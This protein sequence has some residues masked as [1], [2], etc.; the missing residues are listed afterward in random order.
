MS[1]ASA[2]SGSSSAAR[3]DRTG[4]LAGLRVIEM[5]GLGPGPFCAMLLADLG[6]DVLRIGRPGEQDHVSSLLALER[7]KAKLQL[8]LKE[9]ASVSALLDLIAVSD[10]LIE[11][12]RPGVMERLGLGPNACLRRNPAL[13][14]GRMTGWGQDG[15]LAAAAGHD[16][17]YIALSGALAAIGPAERPV[18]PLNLVGDFGGGALYL[19]VGILAALRSAAVTGRG[20]VVDAAMSEGAA[21]LMTPFYG[22]YASGAWSL[23]RAS[24]FADGGAHFYSI[25]QSRDGHWWTVAAIEPQFYAAVVQGLGLSEVLPLAEQWD[26]ARW[27]NDKSHFEAAFAER[28]SADLAAAFD[29]KD[30]CV[31]RVLDMKT[32]PMHPHN[33]AREA[34]VTIDGVLQPAPAPRFSST[35]NA[36]PRAAR[37]VPSAEV[38]RNTW[39]DGRS[40]TARATSD[41]DPHE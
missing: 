38:M 4:P 27:P 11:G 19:A 36:F 34:F 7:G 6:A 14:Y 39:S 29:G 12:Y 41:Q 15:P 25:Y 16:L 24:N 26:A 22:L 28:T 23:N 5:A 31:F 17:N 32:A 21:H 3:S 10:V 18:P 13:V 30:A 37:D 40:H 33:V 20:Q 35:P 2:N 9:P 8:D 1:S